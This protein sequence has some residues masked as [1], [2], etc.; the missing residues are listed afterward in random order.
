MKS[1]SGTVTEEKT[2]T[3][4]AMMRFGCQQIEGVALDVAHGEFAGA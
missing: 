2:T 3:P 4:S 1:G